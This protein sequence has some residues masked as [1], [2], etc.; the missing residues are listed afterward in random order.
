MR[1]LS[2]IGW[3]LLGL[4]HSGLCAQ[5]QSNGQQTATEKKTE[6]SDKQKQIDLTFKDIHEDVCSDVNV[7][8]CPPALSADERWAFV[9]T[10]CARRPVDEK[11]TLCAAPPADSGPV[12]IAFDHDGRAWRPI[13]GVEARDVE[14]DANGAPKVLTSSRRTVVAVVEATNPL[15]YKAEPGAITETDAPVVADIKKLFEK[16]GPALLGLFGEGE[17]TIGPADVA[18]VRAVTDAAKKVACITDPA[19]QRYPPDRM[20]SSADIVAQ[21]TVSSGP[22][23]SGSSGSPEKS[24]VEVL[25]LVNGQ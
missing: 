17:G 21:C 7:K 2:T 4:V 16:L 10:W 24:R 23:S 18:T 13:H 25:N 8:P 1:R 14:T 3:V 22:A 12:V 20:C 11:N 15:V 9:R 19:T 5:T 6:V